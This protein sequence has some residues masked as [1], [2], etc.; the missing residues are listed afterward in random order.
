ME[1][2]V[3]KLHP[4]AKIPTYSTN[5]SGNFD[6]YAVID[7]DKPVV[8]NPGERVAVSIGLAFEV[9]PEW[10]LAVYSRSGHGFKNGVSLSNSVGQV[11][12]D[13]RGCV[14]VSLQNDGEDRF[15]IRHG[16]RIA[17]ARLEPA[18]RVQFTEIVELSETARGEGGFG[19]SGA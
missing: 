15:I 1:L 6:L 14:M 10:V 12:S 2:L 16:D 13:Y 19:S 18:P 3:K 7:G 11:D 5:G 4:S 17:Q 8:I 9:P